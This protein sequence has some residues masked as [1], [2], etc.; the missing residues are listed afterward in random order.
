MIFLKNGGRLY[1][2][3][4]KVATD[5]N[6]F[7]FESVDPRQNT[8]DFVAKA[9]SQLLGGAKDDGRLKKVVAAGE[10]IADSELEHELSK[11]KTN[12]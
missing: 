7:A 5:S 9:P 6:A 11:K 10:R 3:S 8:S 4:V 12:A 2:Y 1:G